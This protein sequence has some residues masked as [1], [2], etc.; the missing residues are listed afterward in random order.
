MLLLLACLALIF[1]KQRERGGTDVMGAGNRLIHAARGADVGSDIF[2][3]FLLFI[4]AHYD[5]TAWLDVALFRSGQEVLYPY[6]DGCA[7][8]HQPEKQDR[9][10]QQRLD[11]GLS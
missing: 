8:C 7:A 6:I 10:Q 3:A 4:P 1:G 9:R 11:A 5:I 2:H